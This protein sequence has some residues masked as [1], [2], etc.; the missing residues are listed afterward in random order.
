MHPIS[1]VCIRNASSSFCLLSSSPFL[2]CVHTWTV[3]HAATSAIQVLS[4]GLVTTAFFLN[5]SVRGILNGSPTMRPSTSHCTSYWVSKTLA[6]TPVTTP[7]LSQNSEGMY[8]GLLITSHC[9]APGVFTTLAT[10]QKSRQLQYRDDCVVVTE[11]L[12]RYGGLTASGLCTA[13]FL[14]KTLASTPAE[15]EP[16][17][18]YGHKT[19]RWLPAGGRP[20]HSGLCVQTTGFNTCREKNP[21]LPC[22]Q[23]LSWSYGLL[24]ACH[25]TAHYISQTLASTQKCCQHDCDELAS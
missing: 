23:K 11:L 14:L 7:A 1:E 10:K 9:T 16:A 6:S 15:K 3:S 13:H 5:S 4:M 21:A 20:L 2:P 18:L 22:C 17:L 24:V 12:R 25:C 19:L 8:D